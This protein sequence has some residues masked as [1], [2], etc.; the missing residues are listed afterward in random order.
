MDYKKLSDN[1]EFAKAEK[2]IKS[3]LATNKVPA[4]KR[5]ELNFELE[6]MRRIR[7]DFNQS[8]A[9]VLFFI[10]K[11]IPSVTAKDLRRWEEEKSL[12]CM[13]I[14]GHKR[15]F[16]QAARNL[17]RINR[18]CRRLWQKA[19]K[20]FVSGSKK[21]FDLDGHDRRVTKQAL[22]L[23][24]KFV[25][26]RRFMIHYL[27]TVKPNQVPPGEMVRCWL[28]YPREIEGRQ[29]HIRLLK[30]E[31]LTYRLAPANHL[32]RTIYFEKK[33]V[34]NQ[35]TRFSVDYEYTS[36][37]VY[38]EID[39]QRVQPVDANGPLKPYLQEDPPH[40]VFSD[41][42]RRLSGRIIGNESNPYRKAQKLFAW[43]DEN[44]PWGSAREYSTIRNL[45][46]YA[47]KN[48]HG[49]CGIQTMLFITLCRLNG[50]PARW[51]SGWEFKPPSDS[52]HDWGM[53]YFEPYGW[54]PMDVTYGQRKAEAGDMFRWFYLH[55][56]D[57]YR[58]IFNDDF[59][60]SFKPRKKHFRSETIDSQR[61]E[62]EWEGGNLYFDQWRWQIV[63]KEI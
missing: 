48:R 34:A 52:M 1:G 16:K 42:L 19:H 23:H 46:A 22:R 53:I 25:E 45:S 49:D 36:H 15:Y 38:M 29:T 24:K 47:I 32:Q 2:K 31:P 11:Y 51:Q 5:V 40:I 3:L 59:S 20:T 43:V 13:N 62:V 63:W 44:I 4:D 8:E 54:M 18:E 7:L 10:K 39:P 60:I 27:L 26:P 14:D 12:E 35:P 41:T 61:G 6:R 50:I 33:T 56:M 17:F 30:T 21:E 28:P 55:G 9:D 37:A 58:L 57:S